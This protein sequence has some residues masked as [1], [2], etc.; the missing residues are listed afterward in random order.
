MNRCIQYPNAVLPLCTKRKPD[1]VTFESFFTMID[2]SNRY[3]LIRHFWTP[4]PVAILRNGPLYWS[5]FP[6]NYVQCTDLPGSSSVLQMERYRKN[7]I[8]QQHKSH[9]MDAVENVLTFEGVAV[10]ILQCIKLCCCQV[11]AEK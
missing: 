9:F 7:C 10:D 8:R 1:A 4:Y 3:L 11:V 5:F 6:W 2:F